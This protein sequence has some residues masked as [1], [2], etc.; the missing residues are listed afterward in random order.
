MDR[1]RIMLVDDH[2][3]VRAGLRSYLEAQP[4]LEVI[5]E[6]GDG[7]QALELTQVS[8]PDVIVM[9]ITMPRMDGLEATRLLQASSPGFKVLAL[10]VH[11]GKQY[12]FEMLAAGASGYITKQAGAEELVAAIR[13]VAAG[14]VYLQPALARWLLEDYQR[15]AARLNEEHTPGYSGKEAAV[16][17]EV[18]TARE[19]QVLELV[20]E[21]YS[22]SEIGKKLEISPKTVSRHRE[23]M[24]KKLNMHTRVDLTRF[25]IR[26]GL[27]GVE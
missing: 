9:D 11:E 12:F 6:A 5:A 25:A 14:E 10:T 19:V 20:A 2:E 3:V 1:I 13:A 22:A 21:G 16:G 4:G 24:M 17:L 27:V 18:L 8:Q 15:L 23:H 26:A 7:L